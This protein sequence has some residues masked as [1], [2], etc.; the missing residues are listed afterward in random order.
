M[1]KRQCTVDFSCFGDQ[2]IFG[3]QSC[4]IFSSDLTLIFHSHQDQ[5]SPR[6]KNRL[7]GRVIRLILVFESISCCAPRTRGLPIVG[8]YHHVF[9]THI[10]P[11]TLV[12]QIIAQ[13]LGSRLAA[14][15]CITPPMNR[16]FFVQ[17]RLFG[18]LVLKLSTCAEQVK[19]IGCDGIV[20][21]RS[22]SKNTISAC[23]RTQYTICF[24]CAT[25]TSHTTVSSCILQ[26]TIID[27]H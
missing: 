17:S 19:R 8:G 1:I 11:K 25:V 15:F 20:H 21:P 22:L 26:T 5:S 6:N 23:L 12:R 10:Y 13:P 7:K 3:N 4:E 18:D 27:H 2:E 14:C 24:L 16:V 9:R